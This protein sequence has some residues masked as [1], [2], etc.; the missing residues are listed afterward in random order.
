MSE[1]AVA[2][3][4]IFGGL[5]LGLLL[6]RHFYSESRCL[7]SMVRIPMNLTWVLIGSFMIIGGYTVAGVMVLAAGSY[8]AFSNA[9]RIDESDLREETG[10]WR[11]RAANWS[12]VNRSG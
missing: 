5:A 8:F 12:P 4:I 7:E 9:R 2:G 1:M 6:S 10:G 11:K 3:V